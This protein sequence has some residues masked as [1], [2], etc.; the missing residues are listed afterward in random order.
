MTIGIFNIPIGG[1]GC[2][3]PFLRRTF[4]KIARLMSRWDKYKKSLRHFFKKVSK[5]LKFLVKCYLR[6]LSGFT[7][8]PFTITSK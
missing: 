7:V 6:E 8:S 1:V 2:L 4:S 5:T 3:Q